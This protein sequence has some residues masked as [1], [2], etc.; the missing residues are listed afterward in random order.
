VNAMP[1][2]GERVETMAAATRLK[3]AKALR[4]RSKTQRMGVKGQAT[5]SP[6]EISHKSIQSQLHATLE[7]NDLVLRFNG[8]DEGA[9]ETVVEQIKRKRRHLRV[10]TPSGKI[11]QF[12]IQ[13]SGLA[14]RDVEIQRLVD[15]SPSA[16]DKA[17]AIEARMRAKAVELVMSGTRWL[18]ATELFSELVK[19]PS[20]VHTV[21][22]RWRKQGRIFALQTNGVQIYPRYSFDAMVKPV[23]ILKDALKVLEGRSPFQIAAWFESPSCS[24]SGKRPREVLEQDGLAVVMAAKRHFEGAVHG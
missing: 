2:T 12:G 20:N 24:L 11:Y 4:D 22:S 18:T 10:M 7:G 21:L 15:A 17:Q 13:E 9:L 3:S 16:D 6:T 1:I 19:K 5:K 14:A 23:P 8:G